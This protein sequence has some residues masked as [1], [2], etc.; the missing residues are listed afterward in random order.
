MQLLDL[1]LEKRPHRRLSR[2]RDSEDVRASSPDIRRQLQLCVGSNPQGNPA[3]LRERF[4]GEFC[5][6][7]KS[8]R[9]QTAGWYAEESPPHDRSDS[10][11]P[12]MFGRFIRSQALQLV[13]AY[14]VLV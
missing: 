11:S 6:L 5:T 3:D 13:Q 7:D 8:V 10:R 14:S 9:S 4:G 12:T 2:T 1:V